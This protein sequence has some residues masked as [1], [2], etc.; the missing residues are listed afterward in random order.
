MKD[1]KRQDA[2]TAARAEAFKAMLKKARKEANKIR[3]RDRRGRDGVCRP[4]SHL[5]VRFRLEL[6]PPAALVTLMQIEKD[7]E[8]EIE[9]KPSN[10]LLQDLAFVQEQK[11]IL[12]QTH[13]RAQEQIEME[14]EGCPNN[15]S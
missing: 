11:K 15:R 9:R 14:T 7:L 13:P 3:E 4:D 10:N 12:L 5:A 6:E 2:E 8:R 1:K